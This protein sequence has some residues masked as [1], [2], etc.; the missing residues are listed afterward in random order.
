MTAPLRLGRRRRADELP[1][2][3][4]AKARL[5]AAAYVDSFVPD[6]ERRRKAIVE[7]AREGA[8]RNFGSMPHL[9]VSSASV[10][11]AVPPPATLSD[12][13]QR[14]SDYA[15]RA[16]RELQERATSIDESIAARYERPVEPVPVATSSVAFSTSVAPPRVERAAPAPVW[17]ESAA[18][19]EPVAPARVASAAVAPRGGLGAILARKLKLVQKSSKAPEPVVD[20]APAPDV[21]APAVDAKTAPVWKAP[22][23][24]PPP[25]RASKPPPP[26]PPP[27]ASKPPPPPPPP[28]RRASKPPPPPPPPLAPRA[29]KPPRRASKPPPPPP[30]RASKPRKPAADSEDKSAETDRPR[31]ETL[32]EPSAAARPRRATTTRASSSRDTKMAVSMRARVDRLLTDIDVDKVGTLAADVKA[33]AAS[34]SIRYDG[35]GPTVSA[36]EMETYGSEVAADAPAG[37]GLEAR[38][39][40]ELKAEAL[41]RGASLVG[42]IEKADMVAA[43][44]AAPVRLAPA[45]AP[46]AKAA[47]VTKAAPVRLA[48]AAKAAKASPAPAAK[49]AS[50]APAPAA[51]ASKAS[52][53]P[54]PAAKAAKASPAPAPVAKAAKAS[55]VPAPAPTAKAAPAPAPAPVR[56][57]PAA[58][59]KKA[60]PAPAP[61][62]SPAPEP[63]PESGA[64]KRLTKQMIARVLQS[65]SHYDVLGIEVEATD[66]D[67]KVAY[68]DLAILV[69]PDKCSEKGAAEAFKKVNEAKKVL[70]DSER[71]ATYDAAP[72]AAPRNPRRRAS[73]RASRLDRV[74]AQARFFQDARRQYRGQGRAY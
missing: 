68:R 58:K 15:A 26:P 48:P 54:A 42:C 23:P 69:H 74:A 44:R 11:Y 28:P 56:P 3:A 51:K 27:L 55:P 41:A 14:R 7:N 59:A 64:V 37:D 20:V 31:S 45:A 24:P 29:S 57:A 70:G 8:A 49:A 72:G 19:A 67:V 18:V 47:P 52:P 40:K 5:E 35:V 6:G 1:V 36:L 9:P 46:A 21:V 13:D 62:A 32:A 38:S 39:V 53:A 43:I 2:D 66:R 10:A 34:L 16:M 4:A 12:L 17:V 63:A 30:L 33:L 61:A 50:P 71:R 22:P 73:S 60:S 65:G 25:R